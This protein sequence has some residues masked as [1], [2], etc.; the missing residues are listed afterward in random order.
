M[1]ET[2]KRLA[3]GFGLIILGLWAL[4]GFIVLVILIFQTPESPKEAGWLEWLAV[5]PLFSLLVVFIFRSAYSIG[6]AI[7]G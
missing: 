1:V 5:I 3:I 6:E 4:I 2:L 7:R